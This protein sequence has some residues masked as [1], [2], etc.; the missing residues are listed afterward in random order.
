MADE[1]F[2]LVDETGRVIG[3]AARHEVHGNPALLH[4]VVHCIVTNEAG[5]LLLQLRSRDKDIQ[6]GKWDTS[7]G[8]HVSFGEAVEAALLRELEEEIGLRA[9]PAHMRFLY[10]YVW[11][12]AVES[13]LVHTFAYESEGPF[14]RQVSEVDD[15]RFWT[16]S[17]I[18]ASLGS[19]V[20]TPNFELEFGKFRDAQGRRGGGGTARG[21]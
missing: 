1:I 11:R 9:D 15:L 21:A 5:D 2:P 12:S 6:P 8:G 7:V 10:K 18:E 19:G 20:F 13:E 3:S 17:E 14:E 16:V 4:P